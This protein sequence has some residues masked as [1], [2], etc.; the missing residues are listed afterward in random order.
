MSC[1]AVGTTAT[2]SGSLS[3]SPIVADLLPFPPPVTGERRAATAADYW[4][5]RFLAMQADWRAERTAR[6]KAEQW[7]DAYFDQ[8]CEH[9]EAFAE[10]RIVGPA[11]CWTRI[12][13][14]V[15]ATALLVWPLARMVP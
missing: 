13:F 11:G 4:H 6:E 8:L 2:A 10:G 7:R 9:A 12:A 14:A 1:A 5:G 3:G 15:L